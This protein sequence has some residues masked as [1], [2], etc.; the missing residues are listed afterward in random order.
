MRILT[1]LLVSTV[2]VSAWAQTSNKDLLVAHSAEFRQEVIQVTEGVYVAIGFG[3]ANSILIEGEDGVIIIDTMEGPKSA[4]AVKAEFDKITDKPV[5]AII[6]THNHYDH[7]YGA[8]VFAGDD[9]P[10]VYA[11]ATL[12]GLVKTRQDVVGPAIYP[13]SIRQFGVILPAKSRPNAG[14]GPQ[15]VFGSP[16]DGLKNYIA[17]TQTFDES[18]EFE[19]AGLTIKLVLAPG[20]TDDQ[21]YV[22]IPEKKVLLPGDN[23]YKAF[24]NLYAVRGTPYRDVRKWADSLDK[25]IAEGPEFLVPSHTRP[26]SGKETIKETLENY[27]DAIRYVLD[28]T[29]AG[30]NE[31]KSP[32]ELAHSIKLPESLAHQPYLHEYYGTVSWSVRS[33][34]AG[35]L[36]WFDGNATNLFP[37]TPAE[38]AQNMADLAGGT[39]ALFTRAKEARAAGKNQ[40][41]A[42][43]A[44]HVLALEPA[45]KEARKLKGEALVALA[46]GQISAN[47]RNYYMTSGMQHGA[48][49]TVP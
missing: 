43:L 16:G 28:E 31:G 49:P 6:Y 42:Q 1:F 38:S 27:R 32:D 35:Y 3:L 19:V 29:I 14:I 33:I 21:L 23:F 20:E 41:A 25:M 15:L 22:W 4:K 2:A 40:W 5:K 36:G 34:F 8:K 24:P 17:P 44:D 47:G 10:E 26:L 37:L 30:M 13:R 7:V 12:D 11:H 9:T 18:M 48:K 46:D 39:D 45:N